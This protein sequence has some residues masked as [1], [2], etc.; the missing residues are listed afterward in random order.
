MILIGIVSQIWRMRARGS[1]FDD[2]Y[3]VYDNN[4]CGRDFCMEFEG[5]LRGGVASLGS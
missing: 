3:E 4:S 2:F 5:I 1:C